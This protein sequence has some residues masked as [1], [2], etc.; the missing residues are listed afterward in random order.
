MT[1]TLTGPAAPAAPVPSPRHP[2]SVVNRW[3]T[4]L[5]AGWPLMMLLVLY[6]LWWALGLTV[7][8][9]PLLAVP[10]A[11]HLYRRRSVQVPPGFGL[12]LLLL[13][14]VLFSVLM[15]DEVAP[16]TL[17]TSGT[18][19]YLAAGIR[20]GQYLSFTVIMLYVISLREWEMSRAR[21]VRLLGVMCLVTVIGGYV[22]MLAPTLSF[23]APL[24]HLLPGAIASDPFVQQLMSVDVAQVQDVLGDSVGQ[25][26]PSAPFEYTN[27]WGENVCLLLVWLVAGWA[28]MGRGALRVT[29]VVVALLAIVPVV[30]SLN[31]GLWVGLGLAVAYVAVRLAARGRFA[32]LAGITTGVLL[33]S[34]LL[35]VTPLGGLFNERLD[36]GHSD[37]I[38]ETLSAAAVEAAV[39]SPVIGYGGNRALIGSGRSIAIGKSAECPQCGNRELGSNGALWHL[40]VSQG[41]AGALLYN[42]FLLTIVWRYRHDDSAIGIAGS[43]VLLLMLFF[44]TAYGAYDSALAYALISVGLLVRND[45]HRRQEA[46]RRVAGVEVAR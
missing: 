1:A 16:N 3:R 13:G 32:T 7:F 15:L 42:L 34:V 27:F 35:V 17:P 30:Y 37:E 31:R 23:Q 33:L 19:R 9:Y 14:L 38:R 20:F 43:A 29:G 6:P 40:L 10:M 2:P 11:F 39:S 25:P 24:S 5:P 12:W 4:R 41:F 28:V 21:I 26:R 45:V 36:N 8:I 22:G 18:G 44:Q 46:A